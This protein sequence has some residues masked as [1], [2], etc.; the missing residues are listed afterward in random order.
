MANYVYTYQ[1][2]EFTSSNYYILSFDVNFG[3]S[4]FVFGHDPNLTSLDGLFISNN[5]ESKESII[6]GN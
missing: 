4:W 2:T 1:N 3:N 6:Y 5:K